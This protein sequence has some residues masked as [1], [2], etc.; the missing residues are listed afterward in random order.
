MWIVAILLS[1][2]FWGIVSV[3]D[4]IL[5][6]RYEKNITVLM[7]SQALFSVTFL[8][9]IALS[10]SLRSS[11]ALPLMLAGLVSYLG[12]RL[13]F[14]ILERIDASVSNCAWAIQAI[15]VSIAGFFLFHEHWT[16][17]QT[18][19]SILIIV[20]TVF[21]SLWQANI[22][23]VRT[24]SMLTGLALLYLPVILIEKMALNE[25]G[26]PLVVFFWSILARELLAL[27][28]PSFTKKGRHA[29]RALLKKADVL[30]F[31]LS[32]LVIVTFFC[33]VYLAILAY[34]LGP[35]S[36]VAIVNNLQPFCVLFIAWIASRLFPRHA[37]G[38]VFT[39]QSLLIK[40][41]AFSVAFFGLALL[42]L[43]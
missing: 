22:S 35:I 27:F 17:L 31:L 11:W 32:G 10:I 13:F 34:S 3:C 20:A 9:G 23:F 16:A 2:M 5:V 26:D 37:P 36:L 4:S 15:F 7:W 29:I 38:E 19:G 25:G 18:V 43:S 41:G 12:D 1:A 33:G 14:V 6:N 40:L 28:L 30:F 21:V 8:I 24:F 39:R 42:A